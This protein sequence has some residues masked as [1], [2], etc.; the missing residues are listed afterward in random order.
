[1]EKVKE[2]GA[3]V[4]IMLIC[5]CIVSG[6]V[7]AEGR[8]GG[9]R[10]RVTSKGVL[11]YDNGKVVI[12]SGDLIYL[13][14][15]IDALEIAYKS[16]TVDALNQI[17]TFYSSADGDIS[18]NDEENNVFSESAAIL[19]FDDL[20]KGILKSQSVDHLEDIQAQDADERLIYY[21]DSEA[22]ENNNL[23]NTTTEENNYPIMIQA[24]KENNLTAGTAAWVDGNLIIGNGADNQSY[25]RLGYADGYADNGHGDARVEYIYHE[26]TGNSSEYG[27]CYTKA[28]ENGEY[29]TCRHEYEY[30][31]IIDIGGIAYH[32]C[33]GTYSGTIC[34]MFPYRLTWNIPQSAFS[35]S[36]RGRG[37]HSVFVGNGTYHY[38]M[39]CGKSTDT[40]VGAI[41]VWDD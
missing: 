5:I 7:M 35:S 25:Y 9:R 18:H 21:A 16:A 10:S 8:E 1:M 6:S 32:K 29:K 4:L 2:Y 22:S 17:S 31:E 11:D 26:H 41:I 37:E 15:Q 24:V 12:D 19:S 14:D 30:D 39:N 38:D 36:N 23:V 27:G 3:L 34:N 33:Y 20:Y 28:V 13:A 40:I